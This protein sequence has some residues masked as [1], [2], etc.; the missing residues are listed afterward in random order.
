MIILYTCIHFHPFLLYP[1]KANFVSTRASKWERKNII[2]ETS[3]SFYICISIYEWYA[4]GIAAW[5][6]IE[7]KMR[8]SG[9]TKRRIE[10]NSALI[11]LIISRA[12][13]WKF[14]SEMRKKLIKIKLKSNLINALEIA[15]VMR[16]DKKVSEQ[17]CDYIV[18]DIFLG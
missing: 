6:W 5:V 10:G 15:D 1:L 7:K 9:V 18:Y 17:H 14:M 3:P 13:R 16:G 4:A 11:L 2:I 12:K 8:T